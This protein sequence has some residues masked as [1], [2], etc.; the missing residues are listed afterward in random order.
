MIKK[1]CLQKRHKKNLSPMIKMYHKII[2]QTLVIR[3]MSSKRHNYACTVKQ[4]FAFDSKMATSLGTK[5]H[6]KIQNTVF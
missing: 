1:T 5:A 4:K 3:N 2:Y 6:I